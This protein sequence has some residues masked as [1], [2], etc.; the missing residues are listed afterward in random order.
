MHLKSFPHCQQQESIDCGPACLRMIAKP[1]LILA[2]EPTG[3]LDSKNGRDVM[4]TLKAL[5]DAG[6]TIVMV[7]HSQKDAQYANRV[8]NLFD[9]LVVDSLKD[10]M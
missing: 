8:I 2:D 10:K 9:G 5:N 3:N 1:G 4:T 7:T 6:T